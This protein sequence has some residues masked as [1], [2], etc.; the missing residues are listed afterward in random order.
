MEKLFPKALSLWFLSSHIHFWSFPGWKWG[1]RGWVGGWVG[2]P[3]LFSKLPTKVREAVHGWVGMHWKLGNFAVNIF[4]EISKIWEPHCFFP[5]P[6]HL[7]AWLGGCHEHRVKIASCGTIKEYLIPGRK[8][9]K[10]WKSK[11]CM[12]EDSGQ[13]GWSR[14]NTETLRSRFRSTKHIAAH[15]AII[16]F[17]ILWVS[18][19]M[20]AHRRFSMTT[21]FR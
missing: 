6:L 18:L 14:R 9:E 8:A 2:R 16:N 13:A 1:G 21:S 10:E 7:G 5:L 19:S 12:W 11:S 15:P 4:Q 20:Q 3:I 17:S